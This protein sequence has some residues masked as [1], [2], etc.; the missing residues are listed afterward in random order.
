VDA[1]VADCPEKMVKA[2]FKTSDIKNSVGLRLVLKALENYK[3]RQNGFDDMRKVPGQKKNENANKGGRGC[4]LE[5]D[6]RVIAAVKERLLSTTKRRLSVKEFNEL[7]R[8]AADN[9]SLNYS[10]NQVNKFF[11][12]F[13]GEVYPDHVQHR[14]CEHDQNIAL[15]K[16]VAVQKKNGV[17]GQQADK[18]NNNIVSDITTGLNQLSATMVVKKKQKEEEE[19]EE[20][21]DEEEEEEELDVVTDFREAIAAAQLGNESFFLGE[22]F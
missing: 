3:S 8:L 9:L 13:S 2:A 5:F 20:E 7:A 4:K 15:P 19:E 16:V 21:E 12:H 10:Y 6:V 17:I 18:A 22:T 1:A 14:R 11:T